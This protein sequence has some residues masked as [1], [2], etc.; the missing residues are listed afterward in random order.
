[1]LLIAVLM[2]ILAALVAPLL[3]R[4]LGRHAGWALAP[5]PLLSAAPILRALPLGPGDALRES[6][7]WVPGMGVSLAFR[8]DGLSATFALLITIIGAL[9]LVYAGGYLGGDPRLGR[10]LATL[11]V[12]LGA[13]LGLVLADDLISLFVFWELTSVCSFMLVGFDHQRAEAR[14]AALK[15]LVIT[16]AGGLLLLAALL[17]AVAAGGDLGL[18]PAEASS[19]SGLGAIDL[20]THSLYG[21]IL[22]LVVVAAATKSA[23]VPFHFWLP[24]AMAAPTPVSA[25][26]HSATMVKAGVYLLARLHPLLGGTPE[27]RWSVTGLGL[28]TMLTG[29][30]M[31]LPQRDLK[32]ILAYSTVAVLGILTMLLGVGSDLAIK[33]AVVFLVAHALYK[34]ALFMVAGSIDHETGTRDITTLGGLRRLMPWTA[35]AGL[36]AA[37]SKAGAPPMFGFVSKEILYKTKLDLETLGAWLVAAAVIANVA[38]VATALMVAVRPFCGSLRPTPKAAHEAPLSMVIGPMLLAIAGLGVLVPQAFENALGSG[39]ATAI[40]GRPVLMDLKLWHGLNT[41]ALAVMGLSLL[42]LAAGFGLYLVTRPRLAGLGR[43]LE[44]VGQW[45][46]ARLFERGIE[47]LPAAAGWLTARL[48]TGS[49]RHYL[50]VVVAAAVAVALPPLASWAMRAQRLAVAPPDPFAGLLAVLLVGGSLITVLLRSRLASV[51]AL[52]VTG[53]AMAMVFLVYS[54]PD[55]A[56]TQIMVETL[57]VIVLV[58]VFARLPEFVR[59]SSALRRVR[60]IVLSAALGLTMTLLVLISSQVDLENTVSQAYLAACVTEAK[61]RNVVNVILVDFRALDTLGEITVVAVAAFGVAALIGWRFGLGR[62]A[63]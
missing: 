2:P 39:A 22:I 14:A 52:G 9:I 16:A 28:L 18:S 43:A 45:G 58:L 1:M 32:K 36:L 33:T 59:R 47:H 24:A 8:L 4:R 21:A 55:L 12:F 17:M 26:L 6:L 63:P 34:A 54:A 60:D 7:A 46:P 56:M 25:F 31:A 11:L 15:A 51:A 29:A 42:T 37:L 30:A 35:A 13:M 49:L 3:A 53:L 41:D 38:L 23:Q 50:L 44:W 62:R 20:R 61:G 10:L 5:V 27:W 40:A 19:F 57:S 48:Q